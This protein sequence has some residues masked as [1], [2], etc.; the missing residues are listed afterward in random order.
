MRAD[1]RSPPSHHSSPPMG[2]GGGLNLQVVDIGRRKEEVELPVDVHRWD[3]G[4]CLNSCSA[5]ATTV[6]IRT[7]VTRTATA[8]MEACGGSPLRA[9]GIRVDA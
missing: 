4:R 8:P 3:Q 2:S 7:A 9:V 6:C 1:G 5:T